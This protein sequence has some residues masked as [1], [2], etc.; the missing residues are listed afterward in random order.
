MRQ[1][2]KITMVVVYVIW[3]NLMSGREMHKNQQ[4][5][6]CQ[7]AESK[8]THSIEDGDVMRI[9]GETALTARCKG[10]GVAQQ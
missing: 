2:E 1:E 5:I 3:T 8:I 6:Q 7:L 9:V 4:K 10:S